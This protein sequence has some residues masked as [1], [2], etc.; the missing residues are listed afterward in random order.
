[1][2]NKECIWT[3]SLNVFVGRMCDSVQLNTISNQ[4][5]FTWL[6][7]H[8][9]EEV[10]SGGIW[11]CR[12]QGGLVIVPTKAETKPLPLHKPQ[13]S[14][15]GR[16]KWYLTW[17]S[18]FV[19]F[20]LKVQHFQQSCCSPLTELLCVKISGDQQL[21]K[22]QTSPSVTTEHIRDKIIFLVNMNI[23]WC[24]CP[25]PAW[26]YALHHYHLI[27]WVNNYING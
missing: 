26:I 23:A 3:Q 9:G 16:Q 27:D 18:A 22:Y 24:W 4:V 11:Y 7:V 17:S 6:V 8:C 12:D 1:M 2:D 19:A 13:L 14:G 25:N 20:W 5:T 15:F 10:Y 21:Q